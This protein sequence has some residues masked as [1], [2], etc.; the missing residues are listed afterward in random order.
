MP[1][2][3]SNFISLFADDAKLYGISSTGQ[4]AASI[5]GDLTKL[6][7]WTGRWE[8]QFNETKCKA[9]YLGNDNSKHT[10]VM[11]TDSGLFELEETKVEKDLGI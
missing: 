3:V 7:E 5:Q 8:L 10:Y 1:T 11:S 4:N 2:E 6:Q 9:L